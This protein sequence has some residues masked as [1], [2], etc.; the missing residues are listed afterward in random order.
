MHL[1]LY[2]IFYDL[3]FGMYMCVPIFMLYLFFYVSGE[4][5]DRA[6]N[7]QSKMEENLKSTTARMDELGW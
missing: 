6:R 1:F 5:W 7:L 4:E 3:Q 2:C